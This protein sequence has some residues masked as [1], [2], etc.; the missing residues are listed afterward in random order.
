MAVRGFFASVGAWVHDLANHVP[1]P[2][3]GGGPAYGHR[4]GGGRVIVRSSIPL[5]AHA[6]SRQSVKFS[7][8]HGSDSHLKVVMQDQ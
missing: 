3:L 8:L 4:R 7:T 2:G 5:M 6:K 1:A